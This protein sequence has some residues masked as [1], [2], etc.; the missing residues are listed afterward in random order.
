M[1]VDPN[2]K[3]QSKRSKKDSSLRTK[4]LAHS[5]FPERYYAGKEK[6]PKKTAASGR[7]LARVH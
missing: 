4:Q 3:P 2:R 6:K 5:E 7:A 1:D